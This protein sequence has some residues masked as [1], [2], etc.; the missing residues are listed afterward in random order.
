MIKITHRQLTKIANL[1]AMSVIN[2]LK[3][4]YDEAAVL[5]SIRTLPGMKSKD[6]NDFL[7]TDVE[8]MRRWI[9]ICPEKLKFSTFKDMYSSY[10]SNGSAIFVDGD[11]NA[12]KLLCE[13]DITVCPYCEDEYLDIIHIDLKNNASKKKRTSEI[14]H[15]YPKSIYPALAMNFY[16]LIPGG[17]NCN[18]LKQQ[19]MLGKNPYENDIESCTFLYPDLPVGINMNLVEPEACILNFHAQNGMEKNVN[20]LALEQ[21]Y[22]KHCKEAHRLLKNIQQYNPEKI[23]E[24]VRMG[25]GTREELIEN[26][27]GP[28][29]ENEKRKSLRQKMLKDLTGY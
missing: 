6:I 12:Y 26:F 7:L 15:F 8:T 20:V 3:R 10:F 19:Q 27:F 29:D 25:F 22:E 16:N 18:G 14:D 23:D 17:Q 1:H 4:H 11:Y 13:L 24:L 28:I 2:C 9:L 5:T 21:R